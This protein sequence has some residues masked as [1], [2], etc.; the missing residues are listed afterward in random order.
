MKTNLPRTIDYV[1]FIK[2]KSDIMQIYQIDDGIC[3]ELL[4]I[5]NRTEKKTEKRKMDDNKYKNS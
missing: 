5:R 4:N 3:D 2:M 1:S